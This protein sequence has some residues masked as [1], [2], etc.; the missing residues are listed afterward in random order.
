MQA[1]HGI[2]PVFDEDNLVS[3]AGLVPV[4]ALAERAGL[5]ELMVRH[6]SVPSASREVKARTI[7][8]GML[9]GADSID[10]L[11]VLRAGSTVRLIG[12]VRAPSTM[13]TFLRS[14]THGHVLQLAAVNR[15]L[16]DGLTATVPGLAGS[17]DGS[18]VLVDL[19]DTIGEVHGY[20]K[21]AAAFGYSGVRGLNAL[22][23]TISTAGTAPVIGEFSLRRGNARSGQGAHWF[24]ARALATLARAVPGR[25]PLVRGDSAFCSHEHVQAA[26]RA[27]AW[28]SFT[29]PQWPT[30]T[31]AIDTIGEDAWQAIEYRHAVADPDTGELISDAEVAETDFTAFVSRGKHERIACRL[32]VRRVKR[33]GTIGRTGQEPLFDTYR[34]HAFITNSTLSAVEADATHRRHAIIEQVIAELKNGPLAHLPSGRFHAN[35]AWLGFAVMAFNISR[36]AAVAADTPAARMATVL[37]TMI[38]VPARLASRARRKIVHLPTAWP[39]RRAW[40]RLWA[41]ATG[42]PGLATH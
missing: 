19:D 26:K 39:W 20:A 1:F 18:L 9:A 37:A 34:Y 41:T 28:Y 23:A 16:L 6:S 3:H 33:L 5:S 30:V 2:Q 38:A 27:G 8:A 7:I 17:D 13:G 40:A 24:T 42:P 32:V 15:R 4:L 14:F 22:L 21:Q 29:I 12:E 35:A 10:D 36:A 31:A 25:Q 11:D